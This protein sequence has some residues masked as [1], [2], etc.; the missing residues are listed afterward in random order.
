M[1]HEHASLNFHRLPPLLKHLQHFL[2]A[3][4]EQEPREL[5]AEQ[6]DFYLIDR[7]QWFALQPDEQKHVF[8][9]VY[10]YMFGHTRLPKIYPGFQTPQAIARC[11][12]EFVDLS[13]QDKKE[14]AYRSAVAGLA[15]LFTHSPP[16][17]KV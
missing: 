11:I 3:I 4:Q 7:K 6:Y 12:L 15:L 2:T 8:D 1:Q 5:A 13:P 17:R 10:Q 16:H 14:E 9:V